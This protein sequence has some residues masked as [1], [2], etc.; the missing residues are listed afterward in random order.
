[1]GAVGRRAALAAL[2]AALP[3]LPGGALPLPQTLPA[4]FRLT[5]P[6]A[7][8]PD[9]PGRLILLLDSSASMKEKDGTGQPKIA[10]AKRA[11]LELIPS[12]EP[13]ALVGLR[14]FG[15]TVPSRQRAAACRDTQ[16]A[17]PLGAGNRA[18]LAAAV[19]AVKPLGQAPV[20]YTLQQALKDVGPTGARSILLVSGGGESC[21][22]DACPAAR[23]VAATGLDL[24]IDV[25][26][27][28]VD[29][30]A[31]RQLECIAAAGRGRYD[32][33]A[34]ADQLSSTLRTA[35]V[36]AGRAL[37]FSGTQVSGSPSPTRPGPDL[38]PGLYSDLLG[39]KPSQRAYA[40]TTR[41]GATYHLSAALRPTPQSVTAQDG[42]RLRVLGRDGR[43]CVEESVQRVRPGRV[44]GLLVASLAVTVSA[45]PRD[46]RPCGKAGRVTVVVAR[47]TPAASA[48]AGDTP[49]ELL[50]VEEPPVISSGSLPAGE[51]DPSPDPVPVREPA[52]ETTGGSSLSLAA[53]LAA[54]SWLDT[55]KPG[56]TLVY[57]VRTQWG[58]RAVLTLEALDGGPLVRK[59]AAG[60]H[61]VPV[62]VRVLSSDGSEQPSAR[63]SRRYNGSGFSLTTAGNTARYLDRS[64]S[65]PG[66][67]DLAGYQYFVVQAGA[68]TSD[69]VVP[70]RLD[71]AVTGSP[72]GVPRFAA[73]GRTPTPAAAPPPAGRV[74]SPAGGRL[75]LIAAL[76]LVAFAALGLVAWRVLGVDLLVSGMRRGRL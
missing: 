46:V 19:E 70:L 22:K 54:G 55:V 16:L 60:A 14:V 30:Q 21:L 35:S 48:E 73:L 43:Q 9:D 44:D 12:L 31:R 63:V 49:F 18:Q 68:N 28:G 52:K 2:A 76:A 51:A 8:V 67:S 66:V 47:D 5:F 45:D 26:G 72:G 17:V 6:R 11:L 65:A 39:S 53:T 4:T 41:A 25:I 10:G 71:V 37:S 27:L 24:K 56:E 40:V 50:V 34:D 33:A 29:G 36:R 32:A 3:L 74:A 13:R 59:A 20:G 61:A 15:G 64:V 38:L 75:L 58:Q 23:Q 69:Y 62:D 42:F 1:M 57:R 7:P